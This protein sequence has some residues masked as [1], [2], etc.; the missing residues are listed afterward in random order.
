ML[1]VFGCFLCWIAF[2]WGHFRVRSKI[3]RLLYDKNCRSLDKKISALEME[4]AVARTSQ[5]DLQIT[6]EKALNH[7][8]QKAFVVIGINTAFS[9]RK[10]R[11]SIRE[12]WMPQGEKLKG[13][14]DEPH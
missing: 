7:T 8:L 12:T 11:E 14:V 9:S 2:K 4:L 13:V 6:G 3:N 10:R 1:L 5:T